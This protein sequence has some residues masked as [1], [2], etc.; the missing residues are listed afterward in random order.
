MDS[1]PPAIL[2]LSHLTQL[3][4][5]DNYI[6]VIPEDINAL[7]EL[8]ILALWDNPISIYPNTLGDLPQLEYFDLLHNQM[9][10]ATQQRILDLLPRTRIIV[11]APCKCED[12]E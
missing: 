1:I 9:N 4:L 8:R 10:V 7:T 5:G 11:S 12:G 6:R 3:D 2:T